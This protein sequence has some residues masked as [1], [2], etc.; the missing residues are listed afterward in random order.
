MPEEPCDELH[1]SLETNEKRKGRL[2]LT[3]A[4]PL[5][6]IFLVFTAWLW[7]PYPAVETEGPIEVVSTGSGP[8]GEYQ[9]N[10]ILRWTTGKVCQPQ[11]K[12]VAQIWAVAAFPTEDGAIRIRTD[13]VTRDFQV[14]RDALPTCVEGNRTS[15]YIDGNLSSGY[16]DFEVEACVYNISPRPICDVYQGPSNI[17]VIRIAG[18]EDTI[19]PEESR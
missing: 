4:I 7:W 12:T 13:L 10:D 2:L 8:N 3:V 16:Y 15:V 11:G 19:L 18:N 6:V 9:T 17:P 1:E 5:A 14:D